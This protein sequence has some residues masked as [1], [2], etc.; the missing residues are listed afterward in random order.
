MSR[1]VERRAVTAFHALPEYARIQA[2]YEG[3]T[4]GEAS[5]EPWGAGPWESYDEGALAV[6]GFEAEGRS[7][8]SVAA[9]AGYGCGDFY[10]ALWV[11]FELRSDGGA[12]LLALGHEVL[13]PV[14]VFDL[15]RDGEIEVLLHDGLSTGG[16]R[17]R[18]TVSIEVPFFD[19]PC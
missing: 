18:A 10:G 7:L 2:E 6:R 5:S 16:V 15:E 19:C 12:E 13:P 9:S 1:R 11:V 14:A 8:V 3:L 4:G 17:E